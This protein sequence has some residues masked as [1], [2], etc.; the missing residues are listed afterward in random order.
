MMEVQNVEA[1]ETK[2]P[3]AEQ[4][5]NVIFNLSLQEMKMF[6][7]VKNQPAF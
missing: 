4:F 5:Y 3:T 7:S 2:V 6:L 1:R